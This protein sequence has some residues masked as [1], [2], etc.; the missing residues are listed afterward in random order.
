MKTVYSDIDLTF[1]ANPITGDVGIRT[2]EAAVKSAVKMLVLT[3][4]YEKP[5]HSEIGSPV[6]GMQFE[7]ITPMTEIVLKEALSGLIRQYEPRVDL[8][9]I[10]VDASPDNNRLFISITFTIKNTLQRSNLE[11]SLNR[12]R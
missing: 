6:K 4:F 8:N 9:S 3:N 2:N 11:L 1:A 12:T 10:E 5:F 7:N